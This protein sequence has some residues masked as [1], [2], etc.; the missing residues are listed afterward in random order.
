MPFSNM[1]PRG[2]VDLPLHG[3][4]CPSW[5]F[6][7][8]RELSGKISEVIVDEYG[9]NELLNRLS[10]PYWFQAFGC[11]LGFDWHSS[12]LTTTTTGALKESLPKLNLG[13]GIAG[14]KGKTS[15]KAPEQIQKEG[16]KLN[17]GESKINELIRT[18]RLSAKVDNSLL[19]DGFNL[20]HHVFVFTKDKWIVIQQGL[21]EKGDYARRYHWISDNIQKSLVNEPH[22]AIVSDKLT[23]P[24]NLT[25]QNVEETRNCS[26]DLIKENPIHLQKY[27][28]EKRKDKEQTS[29]SDFTQTFSMVK[30]HF[31]EITADM[32][33]LIKAYESQPDN[34]EELILVRGMGSKNIRAL[35]LISNL[36]HGTPLSWKDPCKFSFT[37]GGKDGW[38]EPVDQKRYNNSIEFLD[39]AIKDARLNNRNRLRALKRLNSFNQG[40]LRGLKIT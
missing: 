40:V 27:L 39:N 30:Q 12:G 26:L 17:L 9:E 5:L 14:G 1:K 3:G 35:A 23:K 24:L 16:D 29:I 25:D 31:P 37:H 36:V 6:P 33:I 22:K 2:V 13:I 32:K 18:S 34:Y 20:Y 15:R 38:P 21:E 11:V 4:K 28:K 8:M 19:Q 10:D 7:L